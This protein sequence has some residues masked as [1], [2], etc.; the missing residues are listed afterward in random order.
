[1]GNP[2]NEESFELQLSS[3]KRERDA[4][5]ADVKDM[6]PRSVY[7]EELEKAFKER[8]KWMNHYPHMCRIDHVEIGHMD[9]ENEQC[10]L[11]AALEQVKVAREALEQIAAP[12][13]G[14]Y[15]ALKAGIA[16]VARMEIAKSALA[17]LDPASLRPQATGEKG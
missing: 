7:K 17:T 11:C 1:M 14:D 9:S 16:L 8:D 5:A 13:S 15:D 10:P 4:Y 3:M 6:V 2:L 12:E